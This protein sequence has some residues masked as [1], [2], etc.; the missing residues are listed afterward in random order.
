MYIL[1]P[2][3]RKR[4]EGYR[5]QS[6]APPAAGQ[7]PPL[8]WTNL[9]PPDTPHLILATSLGHAGKLKAARTELAECERIQPGYTASADNWHSYKFPKDQEHFLDGLRKAGWKG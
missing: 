6:F 7:I 3:I 5:W 9:S 2:S 1:R 8:P 4:I